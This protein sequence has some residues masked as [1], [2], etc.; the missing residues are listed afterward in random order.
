MLVIT[1]PL[2]EECKMSYFSHKRKPGRPKLFSENLE[3]TT[4]K[5]TDQQKAQLS[6]LRSRGKFNLSEEVREFIN[7]KF[8]GY[9]NPTAYFYNSQIAIYRLVDLLGK[10]TS[11]GHN[12]KLSAAEEKEMADTLERTRVTL[13]NLNHIKDFKPNFDP[14]LNAEYD[15]K[16]IQEDPDKPPEYRLVSTGGKRMEVEENRKPLPPKKRK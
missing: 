12:I 4:I 11:N 5:L 14:A 6:M 2:Y 7:T 8:M 15:I 10:I 9:S 3:V 13:N 16:S 1:Q